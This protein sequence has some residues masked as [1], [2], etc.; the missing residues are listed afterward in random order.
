MTRTGWLVAAIVICSAPSAT[1]QSHQG[2]AVYSEQPPVGTP[3][4]EYANG[5]A[6]YE[7]GQLY[8]YDRQDPWLHGYFQR[9][10]AYGGFNSF[11][12]YN[13]RH[14]FSQ[15]QISTAWGMPHGMP[16]SQQF[17]NR[18]RGSYLNGQLHSPTAQ[19]ESSPP[20]PVA[21]ASLESQETP[22][23]AG[24]P[25]KIASYSI[26]LAA[27][28]TLDAPADEENALQVPTIRI[29]PAR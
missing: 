14:V 18:Y 16:Y 4:I 15:T 6:A 17:W 3:G 25:A 12:P 26:T 1:A 23:A 20:V 29:R 27:P 24:T 19:I 21:T 10:P 2:T 11:R 7:G 8:A 28:K 22:R 9:V 13:Y 5:I